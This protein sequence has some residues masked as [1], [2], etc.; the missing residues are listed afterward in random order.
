MKKRTQGINHNNKDL[1]GGVYMHPKK[2]KKGTPRRDHEA[3]LEALR[4]E[5]IIDKPGE[6]EASC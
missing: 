6:P 2:T 1:K 3:E 5:L 4:R